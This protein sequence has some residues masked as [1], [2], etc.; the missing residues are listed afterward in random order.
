LAAD[1]GAKG[2]WVADADD[3]APAAIGSLV[4]GN[5]LNLSDVPAA[6][7]GT[8]AGGAE[9]LRDFA[10]D[11]PAA[12]LIDGLRQLR[13]LDAIQQYAE[14]VFD[15]LYGV[16]EEGVDGLTKAADLLG[17]DTAAPEAPWSPTV[18]DPA[19]MIG[20]LLHGTGGASGGGGR[21]AAHQE[22]IRARAEGDGGSDPFERVG[23]AMYRYSH[24]T[25]DGRHS[26][27]IVKDEH[28]YD[29]SHSHSSDTGHVATSEYVGEFTSS[30]TVIVMGAGGAII[31]QTF[32]TTSGY[33]STTVTIIG[34]DGTV[35]TAGD[36]TMGEPDDGADEAPPYDPERGDDPTEPPGN[37]S[38]PNPSEE[39]SDWFSPLH[40]DPWATYLAWYTGQSGPDSYDPRDCVDGEETAAAGSSGGAPR[41]GPEAV[42]NPGDSGFITATPGSSGGGIHDPS[43][44]FPIGPGGPRRPY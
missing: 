20:E 23:W 22:Q 24:H 11:L 37:G 15:L 6:D 30:S 27:E 4:A 13:E 17:R 31:T 14:G 7:K 18:R 3:Q 8:A 1:T 32:S 9:A 33:S 5:P 12:D 26:V 39:G 2:T 29:G 19:A 16:E 44:P 34:S 36:E 10:E 28:G 25:P 41:V 42:I 35:T 40:P 43:C 38:Q 21:L